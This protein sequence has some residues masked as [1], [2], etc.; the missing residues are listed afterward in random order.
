M[1]IIQRSLGP[2]WGGQQRTANLFTTLCGSHLRSSGHGLDHA[3]YYIIAIQQFNN[4]EP[5]YMQQYFIVDVLCCTCTYRPY[6]ISE[7]GKEVGF[8]SELSNST[9]LLPVQC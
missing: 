8:M 3:A 9:V 4:I 6:M 2:C 5:Y 1:P 7:M